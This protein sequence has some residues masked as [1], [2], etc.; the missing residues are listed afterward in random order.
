MSYADGN[1]LDGTPLTPQYQFS[2]PAG[3]FAGPANMYYQRHT[4]YDA[5]SV[6]IQWVGDIDRL[7]YVFGY[8]Y[9]EDDGDT[10]GPQ[11]FFVGV[12]PDLYGVPA[13]AD[14]GAKTEANAW[15]A[16]LDCSLTDRLVATVGYRIT[17]EDR[18]AEATR[19]ASIPTA[20]TARPCSRETHCTRTSAR[21]GITRPSAP[22]R[23][24]S[25]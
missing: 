13:R 14:Y 2:T 9:F 1:D 17:E 25:H 16:Q 11:D 15:F 4:D 6:E 12:Y 3:D 5:D 19:T 24:S 22:T 8:Y 7:S 20:T 23:R 10:W 21:T 18:G